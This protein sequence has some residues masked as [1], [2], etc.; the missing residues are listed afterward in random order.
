MSDS[1]EMLMASR[2]RRSNAGN[3]M[4]KLIDQERQE[5]QE[6]TAALD[7]DEI[8]LLFQE[9]EG[10]EEFTAD[11][12]RRKDDDEVFS[13]S[14]DESDADDDEEEGERELQ[15]Q[16]R[17]KRKLSQK[18][19]IPVVKK[20]PNI[21]TAVKPQY[22]QPKAESL[23]L[24]SRRTSKRSSV[25]ANK[26]QVYE[27]LA[28][29]EKKRVQIQDRL[30]KSK[31]NL[32]YVELTQ[33]ERLRQ[34]EETEKINLQSL[35][36]FKEEEIYKKETRI[37][38][39]L[40]KKAK[41]AVGEILIRI[42]TLGWRLTP[43][44]EVED[45]QFWEQQLSKRHKKKKKYTRRKKDK[46][47][48]AGAEDS[49]TMPDGTKNANQNHENQ[50]IYEQEASKQP[51]PTEPDSS[52]KSPSPTPKNSK[53]EETETTPVTGENSDAIEERK[54]ER[55]SYENETAKT[56]SDSAVEKLGGDSMKH[57]Q[58]ENVERKLENS[59]RIEPAVEKGERSHSVSRAETPNALPIE[60]FQSSPV[61]S[62]EEHDTKDLP[63]QVSFAAENEVNKFDS[64]EP[65][66]TVPSRE[67]SVESELSRQTSK[68]P[69]EQENEDDTDASEIYEGP[70]QLVGR[71]FITLYAYPEENPKVHDVRP[72]IFGPQWMQ[73]LNSR[74]ENVET[75]AKIYNN[76]DESNWS[77]VSSSLIPDL[78]A[79]EKFPAF[80]EYD[81]KLSTE[82]AEETDTR[83]QLEIKTPAP[84]G[85]FLPNGI[86]KKC[87]ITNQDCQYFD[88]KNGVP[89]ADV[90][91]Y[92]T[93]QQ[94][95]DPIG[96]G[97]SEEEPH[98][99]YKWFGFA[100]GGIFLDV[101]QRPAKG[102]PEGF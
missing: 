77:D 3:K 21:E 45:R 17:K 92:K 13:N 74:S 57:N 9:E 36:K 101:R 78:S 54:A 59:D 90:E 63:K 87:L 23:L 71:N 16:E 96:D 31:A 49:K 56:T 10:D 44:M 1:G 27:K 93:V 43:L 62:M 80:G 85:V 84:A 83:L 70:E 64:S 41:F 86:R 38:S 89:Y 19:K 65:A 4:Q 81:K 76:Q 48:E 29:A 68:E 102:V 20:R 40:R 69:T 50:D 79:L 5:L 2:S 73:P 14:E 8:N 53:S 46:P 94:L 60:E 35:N 12:K 33:E 88:P 51:L 28:K 25:V 32:P 24:G 15:Q 97:G 22:E 95:Q 18:K 42:N 11:D 98:P 99:Q 72:Y 37:A 6:R 75:I 91:A 55:I 100:R 67:Q 39:Q 52:T 47:E 7:E 34:A 58:I 61:L 26:L 30:R 66:N 82:V